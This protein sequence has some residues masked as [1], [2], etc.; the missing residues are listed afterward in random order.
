MAT[1]RRRAGL[2]QHEEVIGQFVGVVWG[3]G[4]FFGEAL[5][6]EGDD[7]FD[8]VDGGGGLEALGEFVA[9]L[10]DAL[11][12]EGF[13]HGVV[14]DDG[15]SAFEEGDVEQDAGVRW[16]AAHFEL[17]EVGLRG[18]GGFGLHVGARG[19]ESAQGG[20]VGGEADAGEECR[21]EEGDDGAEVEFLRGKGGEQEQGDGGQQQAGHIFGAV[22]AAG[23]WRGDNDNLGAGLALCVCD[24]CCHALAGGGVEA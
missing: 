6:G 20:N 13:E 22:V 2:V 4:E 16:G 1:T 21:E 23:V 19:E 18:A 12:A 10:G 24:G 17:I 14:G 15:G 11:L 9:K 8:G 5:S 3:T 7:L